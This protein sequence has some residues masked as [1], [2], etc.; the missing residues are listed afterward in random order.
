[1]IEILIGFFIVSIAVLAFTP[2]MTKQIKRNNSKDPDCKNGIKYVKRTFTPNDMNK[3]G[4]IEISEENDLINTFTIEMAAGGNGGCKDKTN[5]A[6]CKD[7]ESGQPGKRGS[8]G[9]GSCS[10][11]KCGAGG[12]GGDGFVTIEYQVG[13]GN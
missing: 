10:T 9:G 5:A 8:G 6:Q 7:K 2:L 12:A 1:M 13:C 3:E 11:E 4:Y